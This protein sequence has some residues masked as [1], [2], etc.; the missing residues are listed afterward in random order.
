MSLSRRAHAAPAFAESDVQDTA[1]AAD[2]A[3]M[4]FASESPT[5]DSGFVLMP[6]ATWVAPK[7]PKQLQ[8]AR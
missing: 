6:K 1:K 7:L 2:A 5:N 8:G 4:P 3:R